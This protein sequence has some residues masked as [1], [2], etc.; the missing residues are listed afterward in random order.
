MSM[1]SRKQAS[2]CDVDGHDDDITPG[3]GDDGGIPTASAGRP[4][5]QVSFVLLFLFFIFS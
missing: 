5:S 4:Y 2:G 1:T 3:D